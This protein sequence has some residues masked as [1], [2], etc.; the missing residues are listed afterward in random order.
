LVRAPF[1]IYQRSERDISVTTPTLAPLGRTIHDIEEKGGVKRSRGHSRTRE[2]STMSDSTP[3]PPLPLVFHE[4]TSSTTQ[5]ERAAEPLSSPEVEVRTSKRRRKTATAFWERER[6]V[7]VLPAHVRGSQR[8]EMVDW[9]VERVVASRPGLQSTDDALATRAHQLADRYVDGVRPSSV[10]W[11]TN[12]QKRW[13]SCSVDTREIRLSHRL[14][15]VP[16]WVLDALLVHELA[17]LLHPDHS[18]DFHRVA[19]RHPRQ[20]QAAVFLEGYQ[21]GLDQEP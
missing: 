1:A 16:D 15:T 4:E 17:H 12:Q 5:R 8:N 13:G 10:R 2:W 3:A 19:N 6:I 9:L 20:R 11:V 7:V 14:K 21:L 18:A